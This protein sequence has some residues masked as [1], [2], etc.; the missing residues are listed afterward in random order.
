MVEATRTLS[1]LDNRGIQLWLR[2]LT[3]AGL[4][5][6]LWYLNDFE[7]LKRVCANMSS[8]ASGVLIELLGSDEYCINP[9]HAPTVLRERG[10]EAV[11]EMLDAARLLVESEAIE[12]I[13]GP[14]VNLVSKT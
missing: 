4:L 6:G 9:E 8:Q 2:E 1:K 11:R 5:N 3:S 13:F 14:R 7:L 12:D 10:E